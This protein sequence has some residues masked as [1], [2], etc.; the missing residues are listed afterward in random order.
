MYGLLKAISEKMVEQKPIILNL[1]KDV[2]LFNYAHLANNDYIIVQ[3]EPVAHTSF[4]ISIKLSCNPEIGITEKGYQFMEE[5]ESRFIFYIYRY[6]K[7]ILGALTFISTIL[8]ILSFIL[9]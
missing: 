6:W 4:G 2:L 7:P 3:P 1:K 9:G 5:Y 8:T